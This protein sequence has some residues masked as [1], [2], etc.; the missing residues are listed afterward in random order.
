ML[1]SVIIP[2]YNEFQ[3]VRNL[4]ERVAAVELPTGITR[5]IIVIDDG[6]S[7]GTRELLAGAGLGAT[8]LFNDKNRGKGYCVRKGMATARGD[9][10]II[11]DGDLEYDPGDYAKLL[12]PILR[13]DADVVYG[14]R[15]L[16]W[17]GQ[18]WLHCLHRQG[19]RLLTT[20]S[21]LCTGLRL[22]DMETCYKMLTRPVIDAILSSLTS[23]RYT[24][25]PEITALIAHKRFRIC[26]VG[27]SYHSRTYKSG[28][29]IKARDGL[30]AIIAIIYFNLIRK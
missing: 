12:E 30:A 9:I 10:I 14:S 3:T 15:F 25:E 1:L 28:K 7:D 27:V 4:L 13:G 26:E 11:Q 8:V 21:N 6:S 16:K 23:N 17:Q 22:T 18:Q 20:L 19:N 5:E 29:K 24:I 2:V